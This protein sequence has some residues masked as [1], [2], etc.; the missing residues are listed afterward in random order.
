M[1]TDSTPAEVGGSLANPDR[2]IFHI[3]KANYWQFYDFEYVLL[4]LPLLSTS[5]LYP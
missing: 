2:G 4:I 3:E 1:L 5:Y